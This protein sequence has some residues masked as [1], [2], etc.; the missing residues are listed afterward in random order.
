MKKK[1]VCRLIVIAVCICL[2][3]QCLE[4]TGP[5]KVLAEEVNSEY[6]AQDVQDSEG[7]ELEGKISEDQDSDDQGAGISEEVTQKP[8]NIQK[9]EAPEVSNTPDQSDLYRDEEKKDT[10]SKA[11]TANTVS[12]PQ[13]T[14]EI[15][16]KVKSSFDEKKEQILIEFESAE[17]NKSKVSQEPLDGRFYYTGSNIKPSIRVYTIE[18]VTDEN[19][20]NQLPAEE[21]YESN[22][23]GQAVKRYRKVLL[24][25][26]KT[27]YTITYS[28]TC[29]ALGTYTFTVKA[30]STSQACEGS[31][32]VS[33][34]IVEKA[35][36]WSAWKTTVKA[37]ALKKGKKQRICS[38]CGST[39]TASIAK[40]K[41][42][43]KLNMTVIPLKVK[44]STTKFKVSG[45]ATGDYVKSYK[46]SNKKVFTVNSKGKL[47]AK[48][49]GTAKL[50]VTLASGKK[51][52][53]KVKVQK[54][55]VKTTKV[56]ANTT[57]LVLLRKG[58]Y[59]LRTALTPLTTQQK[60]T[61]TS[62]NKKIATVNSKGVITAK[63][64][65][66][67]KITVKSG[68]K[69]IKVTVT[70]Q[71]PSFPKGDGNKFLKSCQ[72]I[73]KTIM[74]DGNWL[75]YSGPAAGSNIKDSFAEARDMSQR[76]T[77]CANYVNFC[78]QD[79]G[80]LMP[81]MSFY[82]N[83]NAQI[84]YRGNTAQKAAVKKMIEANYDII[85]VGGKKAVKAGLQPGDICLFKGHTNVYA[86]LDEKG[87]PLWYDAG[88][89]STS[90]GKQMS[91]YFTNMYR[92]S[93]Y[94]S[95][96]VYTVLR[97]KK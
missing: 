91:G 55:T 57:K 5:S 33:Y 38:I 40:L 32:K 34:E 89:G 80:T 16:E 31:R 72:K 94:N 67:A 86:G 22:I 35:H 3:V 62:S 43:I 1:K 46:S 36:K 14:Q 18:E 97:L 66:T 69:K 88:R 54:G 50:T 96:P 65:G 78:M 73:A 87:V 61:F 13:E 45:L 68:S 20:Y 70:V 76:Q 51:A 85:K 24:L 9:D 58:T 11:V 7:Q 27:D 52:T 2:T 30:V 83:S 63:K 28:K 44:Q 37:T 75:Y 79:A 4:V 10:D 48:K 74:T 29:K 19:I 42:T 12:E 6:S 23:E 53:A 92:A 59:T 15:P 81:G 84:I 41:P 77:N 25:K 95:L 93:Y 90:D 56:T 21:R 47:T 71:T 17:I 8:E 39:E 49:K 60:V 82:S 64:K 26:E